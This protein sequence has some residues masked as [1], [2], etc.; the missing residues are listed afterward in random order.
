MAAV[1]GSPKIAAVFASFNRCE[2]ALEAVRR[3]KAQTRPPE[4]VVVADNDSQ[5]GSAEAL[6]AFGWESLRVLRT[7]G[8]FGNAGAVRRAMD[9]AFAAGADAVWILDDDSWPRPGAL[10]AMLADG[11]DDALVLHPLQIDPATGRFTWPLQVVGPDGGVTLVS[12]EAGLPTGARV[13]SR[14][15]WTGALVP[16]RVRERIGPVEDGLFIRGEDE[17][18]PWRIERAGFRE[19]AVRA[20]VMDHPGPKDLVEWRFLGRRL[21]LERGLSDWKLY[22]KVRNMVWL[23]KRQAGLPAALA[24]AAA[25]A[26]ALLRFEGW[27]PLGTWAGAVA[28][29]LRGRLGPR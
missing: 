7:G 14:G 12:D 27:R 10:E 29:G 16:R 22:Y 4:L 9:H 1:S 8:N 20:A 21:Y 6:E 2:V 28:H 26:A 19:A 5:D 11:W 17:E 18:Y 13:P 3:L 23:K 24:M 25:Y 15:V